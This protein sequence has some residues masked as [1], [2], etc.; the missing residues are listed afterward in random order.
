MGSWFTE[1]QAKALKWPLSN[2]RMGFS[3]RDTEGEIRATDVLAGIDY[4]WRVG[5]RRSGSIRG[6][7]G[8]RSRQTPP[9]PGSPGGVI[10]GENFSVKMGETLT[11]RVNV[12]K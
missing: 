5:T 8:G 6:F 4:E 3:A 2:S 12:S 7:C 1:F 9:H 11:V 10:L